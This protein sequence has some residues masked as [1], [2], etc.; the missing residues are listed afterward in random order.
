M[1][2][3]W[4]LPS[5]KVHAGTPK[6]KPPAPTEIFCR[7]PV[8][9]IHRAVNFCRKPHCLQFGGSLYKN[10]A[11]LNYTPITF[12]GEPVLYLQRRVTYA[13]PSTSHQI[14]GYSKNAFVQC[15]ACHKKFCV[16]FRQT[17]L[18]AFSRAL[19]TFYRPKCECG[20]SQNCYIVRRIQM[21][22]AYISRPTSQS[23]IHI[24]SSISENTI[25]YY[26]PSD[27]LP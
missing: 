25:Y 20:Q 10:L 14:D 8:V 24:H 22:M 9:R 15:S 18:S 27:D 19:Y 1:S 5:S 26:S 2:K 12:P 6:F 7:C 3:K 4:P 23:C 21:M 13:A 16:L 17:C 11:H